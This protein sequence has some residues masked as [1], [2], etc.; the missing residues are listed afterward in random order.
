MSLFPVFSANHAAHFDGS[1]VGDVDSYL[2]HAQQRMSKVQWRRTPEGISFIPEFVVDCDELE[3]E[4]EGCP[5]QHVG[6]RSA[7]PDPEQGM[8][9]RLPNPP[10]TSNFTVPWK[11]GSTASW[12]PWFPTSTSYLQV[13]RRRP[14][15]E[16][17][18]N[19][20]HT[21]ALKPRT[22]I[23]LWFLITAPIIF[24]DAGY[25]FMRPRSMKGGDLHW[26]WSPYAIYQEVDLVYGVKALEEG[27]GFTAAQS[28]L[29]IIETL[30]NITYLY[31][32]HAKAS[33]AA[34]VV[35]F[36]AIVMT[37]SKTV[38]YWAQEYYCGF[39]AVGHNSFK[40][41]VVYWIIPNGFWIVVPAIITVQLGKDIIGQL[42]AAD[43]AAK[44][45]ALEKKR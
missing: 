29:N 26:I 37:L 5:E 11:N 42:N 35:G 19:T 28:F 34:F 21:M 39:C 14:P 25:C 44:T 41:L 1:L 31:L 13:Q 30:M 9:T 24:W 17:I 12:L 8:V 2:K 36:A 18:V 40:D 33:P 10:S 4:G 6:P 27:N 38:L 20:T 3:V 32:V 23:S 45:A 16:I 43:R 15:T 7:P 22:W